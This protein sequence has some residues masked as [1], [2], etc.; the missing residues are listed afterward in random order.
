[1]QESSGASAKLLRRERKRGLLKF[2][3]K[4]GLFSALISCGG[5]PAGS[6][7]HEAF[8]A[9]AGARST[10]P[11]LRGWSRRKLRQFSIG[12]FRTAL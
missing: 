2:R 4:P 11:G 6:N 8:Y 7:D 5:K 3:G 9:R 10:R 12:F 1:M